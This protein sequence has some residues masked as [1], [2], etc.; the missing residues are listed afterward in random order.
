MSYFH[1][2]VLERSK[3]EVGKVL[4]FYCQSIARELV[5]Q[6]PTITREVQQ[7][8]QLKLKETWSPEKLLTFCLNAI[9]H[10]K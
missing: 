2:N 3:T 9:L 8:I 1:R 7:V 6:L 10:L 4:V 5:R